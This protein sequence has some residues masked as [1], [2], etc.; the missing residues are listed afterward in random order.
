M[1]WPATH[2]LSLRTSKVQ[3][4]VPIHQI[5]LIGPGSYDLPLRFIPWPKPAR[6]DVTMADSIY[7]W[8]SIK[9]RLIRFRR[10]NI[11]AQIFLR[12]FSTLKDRCIIPLFERID[13]PAGNIERLMLL[14]CVF[15]QLSSRVVDHSEVNM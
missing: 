13:D 2:L 15:W 10:I 5:A 1:D 12:D 11:L 14:P 8:S 9:R 6:I 4:W 7:C 3:F